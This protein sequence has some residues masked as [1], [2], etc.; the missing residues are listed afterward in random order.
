MAD[1]LAAVAWQGET[2]IGPCKTRAR[3]LC[4]A[5]VL[6]VRPHMAHSQDALTRLLAEL[7]EQHAEWRDLLKLGLAA[8]GRGG[9]GDVGQRIRDEILYVQSRNGAKVIIFLGLFLACHCH[10]NPCIWNEIVCANTTHCLRHGALTSRCHQEGLG[11]AHMTEIVMQ[12]CKGA[13]HPAAWCMFLLH[14]PPEGSHRYCVPITAP[15]CACSLLA[16]QVP[17]T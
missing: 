4:Y 7:M 3:T 17:D 6:V 8:V 1:C 2:E 11:N 9:Q 13:K 15:W 14:P 12:P 16:S 10:A 5:T